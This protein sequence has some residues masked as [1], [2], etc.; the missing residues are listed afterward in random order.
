ME[1]QPY[2][3]KGLRFVRGSCMLLSVPKLD[4][5]SKSLRFRQSRVA[6]LIRP[7]SFTAREDTAVGEG[8]ARPGA[9]NSVSADPVKIN[10]RRVN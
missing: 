1:L 7:V 6:T 8:F 10:C 5:C 9:S 2:A 4:W 3:M